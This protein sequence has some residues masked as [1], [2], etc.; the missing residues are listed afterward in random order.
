[1][2]VFLKNC[3]HF[4]FMKHTVNFYLDKRKSDT[5]QSVPIYLF[6]SFAGERLKYY[7]GEKCSLNQWADK[8]ND[9]DKIQRVKRNVVTSNFETGANINRR[10]DKLESQV[11]VYFTACG[12]KDIKPESGKLKEL[13]D[14]FLNKKKEPECDENSFFKRYEQYRIQSNFSEGRKRHI[15][16]SEG[17]LKEYYP[18]ITF[19]D[20]TPQLLTDYQNNLIKSGL[21]RNTVSTQMRYLRSFLNHANKMGWTNNYPFNKFKIESESYG[22]PIYITL[23][24]RDMLFDAKIEKEHLQRVRDIFVFQCLIGCRVGDLIKLKKSNIVDDCIEYIAGKTKDD[25]PRT[26]RIPLSAKAKTI[27][28]RYDLPGDKLLPFIS[29]QKYND[30][31]R[32]VFREVKLKRIVTIRDPKTGTGKQVP[33]SEIASSHMARRV[34]VGGLYGKGVKNEIIASMSGHA[35]DSKSFARYYTIEKQNQIDAMKLIE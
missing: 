24:E 1:M 8:S 17:K 30:F 35:Q 6:I 12:E 9:G 26:A 10:L 18:V 27:L 16:V 29:P 15:K 14:L 13:L 22:E 4:L 2:F 33:I 21:G 19:E 11:K 32:D 28:S 23:A 5:T 7:T 25:K 31:I 3:V 34:F 20:L